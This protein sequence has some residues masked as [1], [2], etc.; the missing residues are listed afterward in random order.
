MKIGYLYVEQKRKMKKIILSLALAGL[1]GLSAQA[2]IN[3]DG[4]YRVQN[5]VS[6]RYM[7]LT[8]NTSTGVDYQTTSV[9][10][11]AIVTKKNWDEVVT[12]PGTIFYLHK[13]NS[14]EYNIKAQG[15]SLY[16]M[17]NYYIH[18]Q[19]IGNIYRA[20]QTDKNMTIYLNDE[21]QESI[22][23]LEGYVETLNKKTINWLI[24]E[25]NTEDNYL[26]IKPTAKTDGKYYATFYASFP[27]STVSPDMKVYYVKEIDESTGT[28][29]CQEMSG[30]IPASTPVLIECSSDAP[31]N[32]KV[33]PEVSNVAGIKGNLMTGTYFSVG[34]RT[35]AHY[36]SVEF[37]PE[38]M[39][40]LGV[41]A[42]GDLTFNTDN[43]NMVEVLKRKEGVRPNKYPK[44]LAIPH[45]TGY[46]K[47]SSS[48]PKE[49]KLVFETTG[50]KDIV[51]DDNKPANI[52][53]LNGMIVRKGAT[54]AD[55]LPKGV[56]IFKN[57]KVVVK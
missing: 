31:V 26:G 41:S 6:K 13:V 5:E 44:I 27:F 48:C 42:N 19:K 33:K 8:D 56:Y 28:I 16:D 25:V 39:R 24:K 50:I 15:S 46:L 38:T 7:S 45:N 43:T 34:N 55:N 2:Q 20:W 30:I 22:N 40:V 47:V 12:D 49:L 1:T 36:N 21:Y 35:T 23:D 57:K 10:G 3:G 14:D 29:K 54:T 17:I 51:A 11:S 53:N 18:L 37:E 4:Y 9:D 52:Y 32:N